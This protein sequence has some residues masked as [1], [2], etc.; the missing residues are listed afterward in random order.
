MFWHVSCCQVVYWH[1]LAC[2]FSDMFVSCFRKHLWQV[3]YWRAGRTPQEHAK[4][5]KTSVA[6]AGLHVLKC[7]FH[8]VDNIHLTTLTRHV[9]VGITRSKVFFLQ[10]GW[11]HEAFPSPLHS[12]IYHQVLS[13]LVNVSGGH[14]IRH[15]D[16]GLTR[17]YC[18]TM[19]ATLNQGLRE[20]H[21]KILAWESWAYQRFA[22]FYWMMCMSK[23]QYH[24][25]GM[26]R[27]QGLRDLCRNAW[28]SVTWHRKKWWL[29]RRIGY[30][31]LGTNQ[32][33]GTKTST[34]ES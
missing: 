15:I 1:V 4:F 24:Y 34:V 11:D 14:A 2:L 10:M 28:R 6:V 5:Q 9:M 25:L 27:S 31:A 7:L 29:N 33:S 13:C 18:I 16:I 22:C 12:L 32:W 20:S 30:K 26:K 3:L 8:T 19:A 17:F 23:W 21:P